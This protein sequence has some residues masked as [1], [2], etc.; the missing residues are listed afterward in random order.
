[1]LLAHL[2]TGRYGS[3]SDEPYTSTR[4]VFG[5]RGLMRRIARLF[6]PRPQK[7]A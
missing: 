3:S 7:P 1:M 4:P 2:V 6:G 5:L